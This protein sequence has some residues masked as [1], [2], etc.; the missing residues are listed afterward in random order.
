MQNAEL[1]GEVA[2][3]VPNAEV[4]NLILF[5]TKTCPKCRMAKMFLDGAGLQYETLLAEENSSLAAEYGIKEAPT[6]VVIRGDKEQMISNPSNIKAFVDA[7]CVKASAFTCATAQ[8]I[9]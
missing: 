6:L 1:V 8:H 3:D 4:E 5:T 9:S 2:L 7:H